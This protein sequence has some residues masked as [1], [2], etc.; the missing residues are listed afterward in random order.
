MHNRAGLFRRILSWTLGTGI[1]CALLCG[2][3]LFWIVPRVSWNMRYGK[4]IARHQATLDIARRA[5]RIDD[6]PRTLPLEKW[7][8]RASRLANR[9][10]AMW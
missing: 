7:L 1:V 10:L 3:C 2:V 5:T 9:R 8:V 6:I 4:G